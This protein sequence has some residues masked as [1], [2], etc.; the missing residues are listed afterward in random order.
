MGGEV[1]GLEHNQ[2][3]WEELLWS[4]HSSILIKREIPKCDIA[5]FCRF[6]AA[7]ILLPFGSKRFNKQNYFLLELVYDEKKSHS[8]AKRESS[9]FS[10]PSVLKFVSK[11]GAFKAIPFLMRNIINF[12]TS[13]NSPDS[14]RVDF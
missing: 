9:I 13:S 6:G 14:A 12:N 2:L 8:K 10:M 4:S 1:D 3:L 7:L 11:K 5:Q